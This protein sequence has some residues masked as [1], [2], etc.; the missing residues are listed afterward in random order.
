M[1]QWPLVEVHWVDSAFTAGWRRAPA[2][3]SNCRTTGY[4]VHKNKRF[5]NIAMNS[6]APDETYG[7][8]M[9]IPR[10]CVKKIRRLK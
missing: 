5:I 10:S 6:D 1:K 2:Q 3:L 9:A 4:L 8:V 7:E